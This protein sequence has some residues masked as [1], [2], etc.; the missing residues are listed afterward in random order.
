MLKNEMLKETKNPL[1]EINSLA[2]PLMNLNDIKKILSHRFP[3]LLIDKVLYMDEVRI[4]GLKNVTAN[5]F[6]FEGHFPGN[7]IMP[8]VLQIEAMGQAGGILVLK[9]MKSNPSKTILYFAGL[10]SF[11]FRK[12]VIPGD[13]LIMKM[14]FVAPLKRGIAKMKGEAYV[15]NELVCEGILTAVVA[16]K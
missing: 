14:E 3:F 8:G 11:R 15:S 16:K 1:P 7:P 10:E 13:T 2:K 9:T 4:V 12:Q 6:F 5:E